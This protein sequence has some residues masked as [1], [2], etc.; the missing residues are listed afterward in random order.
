MNKLNKHNTFT[1]VNNWNAFNIVKHIKL[2]VKDRKKHVQENLEL[3]IALQRIVVNTS[4][5]G[6]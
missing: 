1:H 6:M 4:L 5:N 3:S 2:R